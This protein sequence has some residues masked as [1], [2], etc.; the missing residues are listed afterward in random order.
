MK[1]LVRITHIL[2]YAVFIFVCAVSAASADKPT[3]VVVLCTLHQLH[4]EARSYS[5]AELGTAIEALQPDV[6]AVELTQTDLAT[7]VTQKNKR[8]YQNAVYPLLERHKWTAVAMEPEGA[9]R[10]ELLASLRLSEG[11]LEREAP[12]K[13]ETF[14]MYVN[15][16]YEYLLSKW[17]SAADVN[18]TWTDDLF[19][20]KHTF[21]SKLYGHKEEEAWEGWNRYFLEGIMAAVKTNP[22]KRVVVIVGAEHGY[23]LRAHLRDVHGVKLLDTSGLLQRQ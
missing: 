22:D 23:W 16:L 19:A 15:S 2:K 8:E 12:Q 13:A 3:E 17:H 4:E 9:R 18:A 6:L 11:T 21:Q 20:V 5:Y 10:D 1:N 14:E 7:K